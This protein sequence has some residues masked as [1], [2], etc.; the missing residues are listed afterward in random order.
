MIRDYQAMM[1]TWF[2]VGEQR[3]I[4]TYGKHEGVK[5]VGCLD[6]GRGKTCIEIHEKYNADVFLRFQ[7]N[8]GKF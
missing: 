6:Y 5:L 2:P 8:A 4:P 7:K 3:I 1:K